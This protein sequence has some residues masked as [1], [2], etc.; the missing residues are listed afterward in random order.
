MSETDP[1]SAESQ[2][3]AGK[4]FPSTE[5][6]QVPRIAQ[7]AAALWDFTSVAVAPP[8]GH[9]HL[10]LSHQQQG[11]ALVQEGAM[12]QDGLH[13]LLQ[14]VE[15]LF[16]DTQHQLQPIACQKPETNERETEKE[17]N[18]RESFMLLDFCS[19]TNQITFV[20]TAFLPK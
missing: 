14:D 1:Q 4:L 8:V 2:R 13:G 19:E 20:C 6:K 11:A 10:A 17:K 7:S 12:G 3:F 15:S 16:R 5:L 18:V 9:R